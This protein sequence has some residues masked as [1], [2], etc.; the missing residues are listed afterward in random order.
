MRN[1]DVS[2]KKIKTGLRNRDNTVELKENTDGKL[3]SFH[4]SSG[5]LVARSLTAVGKGTKSV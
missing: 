1:N 3:K 4:Y 5:F 2:N